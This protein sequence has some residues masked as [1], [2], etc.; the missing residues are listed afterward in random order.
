MSYLFV[1]VAA[2]AAGGT[3]LSNAY[4]SRFSY[5]EALFSMWAAFIGY[6]LLLVLLF[7]FAYTRLGGVRRWLAVGRTDNPEAIWRRLNRFPAEVTGMV[8]GYGLAVTQLTQIVRVST[9]TDGAPGGFWIDYGK[10]TLFNLSTVLMLALAYYC[11]LQ[12]A[13]RRY[14]VEL[15]ITELPTGRS[16]TFVL[17]IAVSFGGIMAFIGTRVIWYAYDRSSSALPVAVS[18]ML[19]V[20]LATVGLG[21]L[22]FV[23]VTK[24]FFNDVNGIVGELRR[25]LRKPRGELHRSIPIAAEDET[26]KLA[27]AFNALQARLNREYE[28]MEKDVRLAEGVLRQLLPQREL[29]LPSLAVTFGVPP[30]SVVTGDLYDA[31]SVDEHRTALV[32]GR[33]AGSG[34]PAALIISAM[35]VLV[36]AE[37]SN[38]GRVGDVLDRL[39]SHLSDALP[40]GMPAAFG[41]CI[42]DTGAFEAEAGAIG[43]FAL[44][45]G[46]EPQQEPVET[47]Q[48][49]STPFRETDVIP[50]AKM[51]LM[52]GWRIV[53]GHNGKGADAP[54]SAPAADWLTDGG[55]SV[56]VKLCQRSQAAGPE[57]PRTASIS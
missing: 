42:V 13:L 26:G 46:G 56:T 27:L 57:S 34:M 16:S 50:V 55:I 14:A 30:A 1:S 18:G 40:E 3:L 37:V 25:L 38:G 32:I 21:S 48:W 20:T 12:L 11:L 29:Q 5:D 4:V 41:I 15:K 24:V 28:Q 51:A 6:G 8:A 45:V 52:P 9:T 49:C 33:V 31:I 54:N 36:R 17:P 23:T 47:A 44:S 7:A 35:L 53:F 43:S 2:A 10:S 39:R 19:L 22:L